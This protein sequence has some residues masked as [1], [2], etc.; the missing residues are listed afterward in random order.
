MMS[1]CE[2]WDFNVCPSPVVDGAD[3]LLP[4]IIKGSW[5]SEQ[6]WGWCEWGVLKP[7]FSSVKVLWDTLGLQHCPDA[8]WVA[9]HLMLGL[10]EVT[11]RNLLSGLKSFLYL[12]LDWHL[13]TL[14]QSDFAH[15]RVPKRPGQDGNHISSPVVALR[16]DGELEEGY[17]VELKRKID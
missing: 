11:L 10:G 5:S 2:W 17:V 4:D 14:Q 16:L 8:A 1:T 13:K 7:F 6:C 3:L 15:T 12:H 9:Q